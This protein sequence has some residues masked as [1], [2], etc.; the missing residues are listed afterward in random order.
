MAEKTRDQGKT[1]SF[2]KPIVDAIGG[3]RVVQVY[4]KIASPIDRRL[5]PMT[6]GRLSTTFGQQVLVVE[7]EGAR[8]GKKR[9]TPPLYF[10]AGDNVV[11]V[12]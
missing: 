10:R 3:R 4:M 12:A 9:R 7:H 1:P 5:I 8:S 6:N 2:L 11:I